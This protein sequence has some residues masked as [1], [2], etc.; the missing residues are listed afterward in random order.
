MGQDAR[1]ADEKQTE[2]SRRDGD[3]SR[4]TSLRSRATQGHTLHLPGRRLPTM[5]FAT[6][7]AGAA[8]LTATL[9]VPAPRTDSHAAVPA[10]IQADGR[11]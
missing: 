11:P 1:R 7:L 2:E 10:A 4:A 6:R 9:L 8:L 3:R 5:T